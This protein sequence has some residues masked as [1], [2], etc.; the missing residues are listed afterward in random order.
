MGWAELENGDL[1]AAAE[2]E[3]FEAMI[4][5]DKQMQYQQ[6]LKTRQ[7]CILVLNSLFIKWTDIEP[8]GPKVQLLLDEGLPASAFI[9]VNPEAAD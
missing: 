6:N 2:S 3:G 7:A 1:I 5:C 4:T 9:I 8:L